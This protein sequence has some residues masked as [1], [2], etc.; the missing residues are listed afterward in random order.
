M[1]NSYADW[2]KYASDDLGTAKLLL[3]NE[4]FPNAIIYHSHQAVEKI[5]KALLIRLS[6]KFP[7]I[8]DVNR[9]YNLLDKDTHFNLSIDI[10]DLSIFSNVYIET[11][12]PIHALLNET[13][14]PTINDSTLYVKTAEKIFNNVLE[15][16]NK[17]KD[18]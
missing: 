14:E 6:I 15:Y 2:V 4:S 3:K 16:L 7:F 9:L 17:T 8:H 18:N 10:D 13:G 12:Y 1:D 11:K 5:L